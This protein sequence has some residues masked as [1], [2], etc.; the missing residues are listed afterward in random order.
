M[1][2]TFDQEPTADTTRLRAIL[3]RLVRAY[4]APRWRPS[5]DPLGELIATILSQHTSDVN[6]ERAYEALRKAYP[7]WE[8]VLHA[9]PDDLAFVIRSGGLAALKSRRIQEILRRL[10]ARQGHLRLDFL[11]DMPMPA[12]RAFLADFPGVGPKTIACVLLFACGH[13][14]FP[15][16]TH[17]FRV[18]TRLGLLP[19]GC[20][21]ERAHTILEPQIP[22]HN[23]YSA[24]VNLIHHGRTLCKARQP[25]CAA[26]CLR[27]C[28]PY[29]Q[30]STD[31]QMHRYQATVPSPVAISR[32]HE[33]DKGLEMT[34][35][36]G[37]IQGSSEK[38][39]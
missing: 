26:C 31:A 8:D 18:T 33:G 3:K 36:G 16:D 13:P 5:H 7:T 10:E 29:P 25:A 37:G 38:M 17:I 11:I 19:D 14:A 6:S 2:S 27:A 24:H 9:S 21:A 30:R 22:A 39:S 23:V 20:T 32:Q 1:Y 4:G 34:P 12:A 35:H 28:C 15:I